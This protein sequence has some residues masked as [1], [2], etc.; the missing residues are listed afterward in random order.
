MPGVGMWFPSRYT[1]RRPRVKSTLFLR[2]GM[3]QMFRR[4]CSIALAFEDLGLAADARD[5]SW[6]LALNLWARTVRALV[7]SPLARTLT[8]SRQL[9]DHAPLQQDLGGHDG[10]RLEELELLEV[11]L[12]VLLAEAGVGE[13]ALGH[14]AMQRHL[15][16]F[17]AR[18]LAEAAAALLALLAAAR[19]LA[20]A[21]A[22]AAAHALLGL[23]APFAGLRLWRPTFLAPYSVTIATRCGTFLTIPRISGVSLRS[24]TWCIRRRPR[25]RT[26]ARCPSGQPMTLPI[27]LTLMVAG[28][29]CSWPSWP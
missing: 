2:S 1:A 11:H 27:S 17:E 23:V 24:T 28:R 3:S 7:R 6:A 21:A 5:R 26:V 12:G 19:G 25:P 16:A 10:A 29:A 4:L 22:R 20:E 9:L 14:A 15:A 18:A 13:A 8:P